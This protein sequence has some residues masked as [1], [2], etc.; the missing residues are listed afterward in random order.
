MGARLAY[1]KTL[2]LGDFLQGPEELEVDYE[3]PQYVRSGWAESP[4]VTERAPGGTF[5]YFLRA[6]FRKD[7]GGAET[8]RAYQ[9]RKLTF[10]KSLRDTL[11]FG[12][13][14]TVLGKLSIIEDETTDGTTTDG[15]VS[16]ASDQTMTLDAALSLAEDD[17]VLLVSAS[18]YEVVEVKTVPTAVTFTADFTLAWGDASTAYRL[19]YYV[20]NATCQR[21][22][23]INGLVPG[24]NN[25][26]KNLDFTFASAD[27]PVD[28]L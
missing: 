27:D 8:D 21:A 15:A 20:D 3:A 5:R 12:T 24:S 26:S 10:V 11:S 9:G 7:H 14:Y 25:V 4:G 1:F 22:P 13:G 23:K 2:K 18:A 17:Y 28:N 19:L 6:A 16:A